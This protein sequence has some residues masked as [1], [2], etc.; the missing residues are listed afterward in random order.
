MASDL[1]DLFLNGNR[2]KLIVGYSNAFRGPRAEN[3][4]I[5]VAREP[6]SISLLDIFSC[7]LANKFHSNRI[8]VATCF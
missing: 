7:V 1:N 2:I 5:W 8:T 4:V 3:Y 6:S